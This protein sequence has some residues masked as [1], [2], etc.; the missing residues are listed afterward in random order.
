M[1]SLAILSL[2]GVASTRKISSMETV[3][4]DW[5]ERKRPFFLNVMLKYCHFR[6]KYFRS[7]KLLSEVWEQ[8]IRPPSLLT[9]ITWLAVPRPPLGSMICYDSQNSVKAV[10]VTCYYNERIQIKNN[11]EKRDIGQV[12][13]NSKHRVS[14]CPLLLELLLGLTFL[15]TMC[16]NT[17]RIAKQGSSP[18]N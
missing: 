17:Q 5:E 14:S 15:V 7:T 3:S 12:Q 6:P 13:E 4:L 16:D 2:S 10:I 1:C 8:S 18:G 11:E 9:P